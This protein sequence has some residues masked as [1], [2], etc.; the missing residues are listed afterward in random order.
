[1]PLSASVF[2]RAMILAEVEESNPLVGSSSIS[3]DGS[4]MSSYPIE[5]LLRSPPES[6]FLSHP[7]TTVC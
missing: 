6:P 7:P 2:M 4:V 3:N 1:M 5:T